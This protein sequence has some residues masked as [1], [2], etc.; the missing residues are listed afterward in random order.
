MSVTPASFKTMFPEFAS[1]TDPRVQLFLD[2]ASRRVSPAA[3]DTLAD[4]A[5]S[6]LSAHLLATSAQAASASVSGA[7]G[8]ISSETVGPLSRAYSNGWTGAS[9]DVP[10]EYASTQ[11]GVQFW[12]LLKLSFPT[13]ALAW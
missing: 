10:P 4:D 7:R 8:P 11:Y 9:S 5:L 2:Q 12:Q 3:F 13:P 1:Q 6:Y